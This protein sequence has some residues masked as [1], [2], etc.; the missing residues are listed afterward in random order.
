MIAQ[1]QENM[2][3]GEGVQKKALYLSLSFLP[4]E[5]IP[6]SLLSGILNQAQL[7]LVTFCHSPSLLYPR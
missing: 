5:I 3:D 2:K 7:L 4:L 1:P 6:V